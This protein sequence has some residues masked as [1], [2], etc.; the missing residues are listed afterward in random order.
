M[1][2][3]RLELLAKGLDNLS[4]VYRYLLPNTPGLEKV[5][6]IL[7]LD[8]KQIH[9]IGYYTKGREPHGVRTPSAV[10][11]Y[12]LSEDNVKLKVL[13]FMCVF[14]CN[15]TPKKITHKCHRLSLKFKIENHIK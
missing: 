7:N 12:V 5:S 14:K 13:Y 9:P 10:M 6:I 3:N 8:H 4:M 1:Y 11:K 15:L 2:L